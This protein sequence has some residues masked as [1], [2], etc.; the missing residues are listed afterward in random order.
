MIQHTAAGDHRNLQGNTTATLIHIH[1]LIT[2][3]QHIPQWQIKAIQ[4]LLVLKMSQR[5]EMIVPG[6]LVQVRFTN[7]SLRV[8]FD[9]CIANAN[10][11][12]HCKLHCNLHSNLLCNLLCNLHC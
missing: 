3:K 12:L 4:F 9:P 1:T 10:C 2:S 5:P 11:N 7:T 6:T 8:A